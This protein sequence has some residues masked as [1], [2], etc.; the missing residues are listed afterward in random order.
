MTAKTTD[1]S[2][3]LYYNPAGPGFDAVA[4]ASV[5]ADN[6]T[7]NEGDSITFTVVTWNIANNA[8]LYYRVA[9]LVNLT[10]NR[11]INGTSGTV[12]I[13]NRRATVINGVNEDSTTAAGVQTFDVIISKDFNGPALSTLTITVNDTSQTPPSPTYALAIAGSVTSVDEDV[14]LTFNITTT[15]VADGTT[16]WWSSYN[17]FDGT[18]RFD[19]PTGSTTITS[20]AGSFSITVAADS[21]TAGAQQYYNVTLWAGGGGGAGGT[22]VASVEN[23]VVNDTSQTPTVPASFV[24]NGSTDY[25]E[26]TGTTSD[27]ALGLTWTVEFW[28]KA[29]GASGGNIQTA[30]SQYDAS[31]NRLD[32]FYQSGSLCVNNARGAICA[33]PTPGVWTHVALVC[34]GG[35]DGSGGNGL[36]VYYNGVNVYTGA[37]YYLGAS[38]ATMVI[39]KRGQIMFQ[40]FSGKLTGIRITNTAV[41]TDTFNPYIEALPP[42]KITGTKLLLNPT[43][44]VIFDDLSDSNHTF[45]GGSVG[46]SSDY[47]VAQP[48]YSVTPADSSINEGSSLTFNVGGTNIT[49]GTYYWTITNSGDFG[50]TSGSFSITS[51]SGS[52]TV[53]PTA[54]ATT[55]GSETFTASIRSVST[56][57]TV[58]ATSSSVTINDTSTTPPPSFNQ[59][60]RLNPSYIP[61]N[62]GTSIPNEADSGST[63]AAV[64]STF[65]SSSA[66]GGYITLTGSDSAVLL[67]AKNVKTIGMWIKIIVQNLVSQYLVDSRVING[68]GE[69]TGYFYSSGFEGWSLMSINGNPADVSNWSTVANNINTWQYVTVINQ[70]NTPHSITL[71][72][73]YTLGESLAT[74]QVGW[75]EAWDYIL[76]DSQIADA[77]A[78]HSSNYV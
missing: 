16:L 39:G 9:N 70:T 3:L 20:N 78:T 57:G 15:N 69:G 34:T 45:S 56:S 49:N 25:R 66:Q 28:S 76:I 77:Y 61:T 65:T 75:I 32:V 40:Y 21:T 67:P 64:T 52:F 37:G 4:S 59:V 8:T 43:N 30:I 60:I 68:G 54:D 48:T 13:T 2:G 41:Y 46:N 22:Q 35:G 26:L 7:V 74:V 63:S 44:N 18:G 72:N 42:A 62:G 36:F 58:L 31:D 50:T 6:T 53:T 71:F 10:T 29:T 19:Y 14:A 11:F 1:F 23:I 73:R 24:F 47:P 51:N 33:E 5:V 38:T 55:E 17:N 12:M 27:W